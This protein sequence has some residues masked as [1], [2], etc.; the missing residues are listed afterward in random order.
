MASGR[1]SDLTRGSTREQLA[2]LIAAG[3]SRAEM[4]E[5]F[6]VH[7]DTITNW[8]KDR[9]VQQLVSE[10]NRVRTNRIVA[11]IDAA[12]E[13]ILDNAD[14]EEQTLPVEDLIKIRRELAPKIKTVT[15]EGD[16]TKSVEDAWK[17]ADDAGVEDVSIPEV[18]DAPITP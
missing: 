8:R 15:R 3:A 13:R 4:A 14:D 7:V 11:R 9:V 6:S 18:D 12:I 16:T 5:A 1:I 2:D 10:R 17:A